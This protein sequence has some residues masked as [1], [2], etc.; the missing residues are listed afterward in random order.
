MN[1]SLVDGD[2]LIWTS[3]KIGEIN[4]GDIVIFKS[5]IKWPNEKLIVH[6]VTNIKVDK[7]TGNLLFETKGDSNEWIDQDNPYINIPYIQEDNIQG[8]AVCFMNQPF[9]INLNFIP[10]LLGIF[11]MLLIFIHI[12]RVN[13][14][15]KIVYLLKYTS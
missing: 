2:I 6:R 8:K 12:Y 10:V 13:K 1:P 11:I 5:Y 9:K 7:I 4:I 14:S 15:N 3:T